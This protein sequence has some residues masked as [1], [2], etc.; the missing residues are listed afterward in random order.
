L[1]SLPISTQFTSKALPLLTL[2]CA[3]LVLQITSV[4]TSNAETR[5]QG[6]DLSLFGG[7]W[8]GA[9]NVDSSS[10]FGVAAGYHI[11][12]VFSLELNHGFIP[13]EAAKIDQFNQAN[14][15]KESLNIQQ[16]VVNFVVNLAPNNFVPFFN[17]GG[18][19][20]LADNESSW[21]ADVGF[22]AKYYLSDDFALKAN[23]NMWMGGM[24]LRNEPYDHFT[25]TMGVSYSLAGKRDIDKDG[26]RNTIDQCP[27]TP[28]D[29]DQF[30]DS[31]GCPDE[32]ND[33]DGVKDV[34]DQCPND[35][36]DEDGDR[37]E[38]GCPDL[39][40]DN[41]GI[42]NE[43][44]KC[45]QQPEDKDRF[46][47]DDGCID[48]DNDQDGILDTKDRCPD[49][50][51]SVNG[52]QDLD[53]CPETD[54]DKDQVF[55]SIDR[56][57][58]KPETHNGLK[59]SDGCPDQISEALNALLGLQPNLRFKRNKN[60]IKLSRKATERL[61][62]LA[63][64][65]RSEPL[66]ITVTATAHKGKN[67][68]EL[69]LQRAQSIIALLR[70]RGIPA[71][72][73]QAVGAGDQ[74]LPSDQELAKGQ[75]KKDWVSIAPWLKK[76]SY[77]VVKKATI[78]ATKTVK[79]EKK[80]TIKATKEVKTAKKATI[81]ATKEVKT[82]KKATIKAT[83]EVKTEKKATIKATKEVKAKKKAVIKAT[84]EVKAEKK[85]TIKATKEAKAKK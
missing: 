30:K 54:N 44:D 13:T 64:K 3:S 46:E 12:R 65:L 19:W 71:S 60:Q 85:A 5:P 16:G 49:E 68:K 27:T 53:G 14:P 26:V 51:E 42:S 28:E 11:S 59:D 75:S 48:E 57:K 76:E 33:E 52:F 74:E 45:P 40:D 18:G 32:D 79:P 23:L 17:I 63:T 66:N 2:I 84:K 39:D 43:E 31:D 61:N 50:A 56:C 34:D 10:Y 77:K 8:E 7:Y 36:E 80:A 4:P 6:Y 73:M 38:D 69:S 20:V 81:K 29:L 15:E 9:R 37:D 72:Q 70:E 67:V 82:E 58:S 41:D 25:L 24:E 1:K 21:T 35:A 78:K 62:M 47:D 55:D 83:K 22:G